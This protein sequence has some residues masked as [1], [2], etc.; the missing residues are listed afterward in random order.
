MA[1]WTTSRKYSYILIQ[2]GKSPG[3]CNIHTKKY[4]K[5]PYPLRI[6]IIPKKTTIW[7][8]KR[9][10]CRPSGSWGPGR[11]KVG[12]YVISQWLWV[13]AFIPYPMGMMATGCWKI[14]HFPTP[15]FSSDFTTGHGIKA[16]TSCAGLISDK[17]PS[18]KLQA[19]YTDSYTSR[20][21]LCD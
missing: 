18:N 1:Y 14:M 19:L 9:I 12:N 8:Q 16:R 7:A 21:I 3:I 15:P 6:Q 10:G 11:W 5:K 17:L 13:L 20:K 4:S 2:W